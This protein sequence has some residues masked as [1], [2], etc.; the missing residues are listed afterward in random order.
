MKLRISD[1][2]ILARNPDQ[3]FSEIDDEIVMLSVKNGEYYNLNKVG[4][5]IWNLLEKPNTFENLI[6]ALLN[7]YDVDKKTCIDDTLP[8]IEELVI[9]GLIN[10]IDEKNS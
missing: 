5:Y 6:K 1:N 2:T 10:V 8:L 9:K 4:S 7:S 3:L